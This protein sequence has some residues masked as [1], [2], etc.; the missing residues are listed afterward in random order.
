MSF[1]YTPT[2]FTYENVYFDFAYL[3]YVNN[4]MLDRHLSVLICTDTRQVVI[5]RRVKERI[6][7]G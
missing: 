4:Q 6:H 1:I 2:F 3:I 5:L 7:L